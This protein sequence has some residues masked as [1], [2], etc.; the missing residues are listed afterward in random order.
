[1]SSSSD[2]TVIPNCDS[3]AIQEALR[4]IWEH[5]RGLVGERIELI[6]R[7]VNALAAG[8]LDEQ[9]RGE[10]L[11]AAHMLSG[12]LGTFGFAGASEAAGALEQELADPRGAQAPLMKALLRNVRD[13]LR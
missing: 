4:D 9:L 13:G 11:R 6:E 10:A 12:S 1:M 2:P 7:A 8:E 5:H 3:S